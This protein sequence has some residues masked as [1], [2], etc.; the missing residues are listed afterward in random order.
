MSDHSNRH[1]EQEIKLSIPGEDDYRRLIGQLPEPHTLLLQSNYFFDTP[2]RHLGARKL[3]LRLRMVITADGSERAFLAIKGPA[4]QE[5]GVT[6]RFE[7]ESPIDLSSAVAIIRSKSMTKAQLGEH[8]KVLTEIPTETFGMIA[9][10]TNRRIASTVEIGGEQILFEVDATTYA[11]KST[12]YELEVE[13]NDSQRRKKDFY[14]LIQSQLRAWEIATT[15]QQLSK[16][17]R[18]LARKA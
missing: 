6:V 4:T 10:F 14:E 9:F 7:Q 13:L 2:D 1:V 15:P 11:D 12:D 18:A 5:N 3:A 16:F 8:G 17:E